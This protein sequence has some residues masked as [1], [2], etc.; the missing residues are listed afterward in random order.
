MSGIFNCKPPWTKKSAGNKREKKKTILY[1]FNEKFNQQKK[2]LGN[3]F[4]ELMVHDG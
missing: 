4:I 3:T 1:N 2:K